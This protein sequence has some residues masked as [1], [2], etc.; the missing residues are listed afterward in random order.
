MALLRF[1][2]LAEFPLRSYFTFQLFHRSLRSSLGH[3][4]WFP[5]RLY[6]AFSSPALWPSCISAHLAS[7]VQIDLF[8]TLH[9]FILSHIGFFPALSLIILYEMIKET[10]CYFRRSFELRRW[11][12]TE[13]L[14]GTHIL[15]HTS[16]H[17]KTSCLI[18]ANPLPIPVLPLPPP[19]TTPSPDARLGGCWSDAREA[20][21]Y[22]THCFFLRCPH[23]ACGVGAYH[24]RM[25]GRS[26]N[27]IVG[28]QSSRSVRPP[29]CL[30][31][32][33]NI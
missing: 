27:L 11:R 30:E 32:M 4:L 29:A 8:I 22:T 12:D 10:F 19:P 26:H 5:S 9:I 2:C 18:M 6:D 24:A 33:L 14:S 17:V 21:T 16:P 3:L 13:L 1:E 7:H 15:G 31:T 20:L 23:V 25:G 28:A